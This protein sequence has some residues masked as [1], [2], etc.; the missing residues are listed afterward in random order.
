[1]KA[2]LKILSILVIFIQFGCENIDVIESTIPYEEYFIINGRL[3]GNSSKF[4]ISFTK[5]F[6]IE[7]DISKSEVILDD[8]ITYI[9]SED[10]GIFTMDHIGN[11][12]YSPVDDILIRP[13]STY[14]LYARIN[15]TRITATTFVPHAPDIFSS[16]VIGNYI[17]CRITSEKGT[18]Y[19]CKYTVT[20]LVD[21]DF[22]FSETNFY[23]LSGIAIESGSALDIRTDILPDY[24][25]ENPDDYLI[26]LEVY[27]FD[28]AYKSYYDTRENNKPIENIFSEGGGSVYWNIQGDNSIGMF[29]G[30]TSVNISDLK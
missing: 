12:V 21:F 2:A 24:Y 25:F 15:D 7:S 29:I 1:M 30:Y 28:S 17:T 6:A 5:S 8:V 19:G 13:G 16:S 27:A 4:E 18:V 3:V 14:E 11:G 9:L 22:S 20:S 10:Q 26:S 23:E